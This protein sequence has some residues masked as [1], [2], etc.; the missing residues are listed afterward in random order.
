MGGVLENVCETWT[1]T[2]ALRVLLVQK[3]GGDRLSCHTERLNDPRQTLR[4]SSVDT[5]DGALRSVQ[6]HPY[7]AVLVD[8]DVLASNREAAFKDLIVAAPRTAVV[9]LA[10]RG[11]DS[12]A[13]QACELGLQDCLFRENLDPLHLMHALRCAIGRKRHETLLTEWAYTDQLTGLVNRRLFADRLA[14]AL[15]RA[16]RN[17]KRLALLFIDLDN[18]KT[19]NDSFGHDAGDGVLRTVAN[20]LRGAVRQ[21]DTVARLGGDEFAVILEPLEEASRADAIAGK[22]VRALDVPFIIPAAPFKVTASIGVALFPAHGTEADALVNSADCAMLVA[23]RCGGNRYRLARRPGPHGGISLALKSYACF[24]AGTT[25]NF[26]YDASPVQG[27]RK[28]DFQDG[29]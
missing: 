1:D 4:V 3:H 6:C 26:P 14:H 21:T 2:A 5:L 19:I 20:M 13:G 27:G 10:S 28:H 25:A 22:I 15:A 29:F 24:E 8:V 9:A 18:F 23:K 7:D 12:W 17:D 11:D 16:V